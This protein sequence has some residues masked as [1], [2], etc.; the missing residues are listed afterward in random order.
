MKFTTH[1]SRA[2]FASLLVV[3]SGVVLLPTLLLA[4]ST[5][6]QPVILIPRDQLTPEQRGDPP[7][8]T[9][10]PEVPRVVGDIWSGE[11]DEEDP[12]QGFIAPTTPDDPTYCDDF[13]QE[14]RWLLRTGQINTEDPA[15]AY[16]DPESNPYFIGP[17]PAQPASDAAPAGGGDGAT[18]PGVG[19]G[20]APMGGVSGNNDA[21]AGVGGFNRPP[22]NPPVQL[23]NPLRVRTIPELVQTLLQVFVVLAIPVIVF[24]IILA[25]FKYVTARGDA[26]AV[27]E[28]TQA[29]T[30]AVIGALLIIGAASLAA[31][32]GNLVNSIMR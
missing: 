20:S 25:G 21:E 13:C 11:P 17:F 6:D 8:S 12:S 1:S 32:L 15:G 4:Q 24:F 9:V 28:A 7:P 5:T 3:V 14:R 23:S 18:V 19:G 10:T 30:N 29:L 31:I 22:N 2:A 26:K 27:G 16:P